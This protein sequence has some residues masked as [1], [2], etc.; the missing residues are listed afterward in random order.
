MTQFVLLTAV[1][2]KFELKEQKSDGTC[3]VITFPTEM[4]LWFTQHFGP[5]LML[6]SVN[7][8]KRIRKM[9]EIWNYTE[10]IQLKCSMES[11]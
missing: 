8:A 1:K 10:N 9:L 11:F 7:R 5:I 3:D 2:R 4:K 6:D